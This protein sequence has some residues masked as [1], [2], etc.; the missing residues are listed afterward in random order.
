MRTFSSTAAA[1]TAGD[2]RP[3]PALRGFGTLGRAVCSLAAILVAA[4]IALA[5]IEA[6]ST[7][8]PDGFDLGEGATAQPADGPL[9][10]LDQ[11]ASVESAGPADGRTADAREVEDPMAAAIAEPRPAAPAPADAQRGD[12]PS[13]VPTSAPPSAPTT[14]EDPPPAP[15]TPGPPAL[16]SI[17][18]PL[19]E[20]GDEILPGLETPGISV[21]I[22]GLP[23]LTIPPTTAPPVTIPDLD[24]GLG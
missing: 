14:S 4:G 5:A 12:A 24:L 17:P 3:P 7:G 1:T 13:G 2:G 22:P 18:I 11:V 23:P 19:P 9:R 8:L 20:A 21:Q 16:P 10:V 6:T 15:P